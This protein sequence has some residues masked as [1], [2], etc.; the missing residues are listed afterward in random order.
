MEYYEACSLKDIQEH[1]LKKKYEKKSQVREHL[2]FVEHLANTV[3]KRLQT[4]IEFGDLAWSQKNDLRR[5]QEVYQELQGVMQ[6]MEKEKI[7]KDVK[8]KGLF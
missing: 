8:P 2:E 3:T 4:E 7:L 6:E 1:I 5:V